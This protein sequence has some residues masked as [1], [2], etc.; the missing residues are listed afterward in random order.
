MCNINN[1]ILILMIILLM[2]MCMCINVCIN[3]GK[4]IYEILM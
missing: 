2:I 1:E 3:N 4:I